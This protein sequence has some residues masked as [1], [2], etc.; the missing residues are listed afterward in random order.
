M[1]STRPQRP[2]N[3]RYYATHRDQEIQRVR[4]RQ[5]ATLEWLRQLRCVPCADCG[6]RYPPHVMDFDHRDPA[7]KSFLI[8]GGH[9]VSKSREDLLAEVAKCDVVCGNCHRVRTHR[10]RPDHAW[11]WPSG[12]LSERLEE[13]RAVRLR[14]R[15]MLDRIRDVPCMD[16]GRRFPPYVME[17]DHRDPA[18]KTSEVM[19]MP[20]RAGDLRIL[21]EVGKCDIVCT[22]CHRDRTFRRRLAANAGVAQLVEHEFSKLGVAGSSPVSRSVQLRLLEESAACYAA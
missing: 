7:T 9:G 15:Q 2:Y 22:N 19:R 18:L 14:Q 21:A 17:F 6:E 20:G 10:Q 8:A 11:G 1:P 16:C 12:G 13:K 5:A 3:V 4:T